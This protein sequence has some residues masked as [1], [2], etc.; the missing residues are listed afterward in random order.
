MFGE[1]GGLVSL[2]QIPKVCRPTQAKIDVHLQAKASM[3]HQQHC[4]TQQPPNNRTTL[5]PATH[6]ALTQRPNSDQ[7]EQQHHT[8][9]ELVEACSARGH[10][11]RQTRPNRHSGIGVA[12]EPCSCSYSCQWQCAVGRGVDE[13]PELQE[14]VYPVLVEFKFEC[15]DSE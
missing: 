1:G 4:D 14:L 12:V 5:N 13:A 10:A 15:F 2:Q 7:T 3:Q 6:T 11:R 8:H 9:L